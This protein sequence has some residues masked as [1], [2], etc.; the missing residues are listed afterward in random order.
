MDLQ[1]RALM[2]KRL[3]RTVIGALLGVVLFALL[4]GLGDPKDRGYSVGGTGRFLCRVPT[5]ERR[6]LEE[7]LWLHSNRIWERSDR[8]P[9]SRGDA[10]R[11]AEERVRPNDETLKGRDK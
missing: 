11:V 10:A 6:V 5:A 8:S 7:Y 4:K 3:W 9:A 2:G 1:A